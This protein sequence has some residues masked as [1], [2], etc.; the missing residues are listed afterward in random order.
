MR[1]LQILPTLVF[2]GSIGYPTL[3]R[4]GLLSSHRIND[5]G[6][7][8]WIVTTA[9]STAKQQRRGLSLAVCWELCC[10]IA[11]CSYLNLNYLKYNKI[12]NFPS[13]P[14][15]T[16][17][18][19]NSYVWLVTPVWESRYRPFPL[20]PNIQLDTAGISVL[21]LILKS[22]SLNPLHISVMW[23]SAFLKIHRP[24]LPICH[25]L[26]ILQHSSA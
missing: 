8:S 14:I 13:V 3:L 26:C 4:L 11:T 2:I 24:Q 22:I 6:P 5:Q 21:Q 23:L 1:S 15:P 20:L 25:F 16:F 17:S 19:F 18:V 12:Q 9:V 7:S 10:P